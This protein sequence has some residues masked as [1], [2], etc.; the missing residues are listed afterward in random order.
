MSVSQS[1]WKRVA[2]KDGRNG[3]MGMQRVIKEGRLTSDG[4]GMR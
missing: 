3:A 1:V 4:L 2:V